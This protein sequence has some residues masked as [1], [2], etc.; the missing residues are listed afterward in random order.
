MNPDADFAGAIGACPIANGQINDAIFQKC[1]PKEEIKIAKRVEVA[2]I[3]AVGGYFLIITLEQGFG[4]AQ[5]ICDRLPQQPAKCET[6]EHIA[7]T[8]DRVHRAVFLTVH[9]AR[10][11]DHLRL[12]IRQRIE[13]LG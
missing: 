6:E 5:G 12:A 2:K 9:E 3:T 7:P 13:K 1:Y 4:A 10:P 8:V 11:F